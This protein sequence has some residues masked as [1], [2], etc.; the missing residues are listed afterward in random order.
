MSQRPLPPAVYWRRRLLIVAVVIAVGWI[1][2]K[3]VGGDDSTEDSEP[4][5][6][7]QVVP[8]VVPTDGTYDA[9]LPTDA[10]ACDPEAVRITPSVPVEQQAGG[11]VQ[12]DLVVSSA[13]PD[14]CTLE[15]DDAD[16]I[17]VISSGDAVVWDSTRCPTSLLD[18]P[19]ALAAGW[20]SLVSVQWSGRRSGG[21]CSSSEPAVG[22]GTYT[23][24]LGT[25]GGEPG[26]ATF[27]LTPG[28]A[29]PESESEGQG[30]G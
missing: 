19:V 27:S 14:P 6:A 25:L 23:V 22:A 7:P 15:P 20:S 11:A 16:L 28:G 17:A 29:A 5:A 26:D 1:G 2:M 30:D 13:G 10:S 9:S 21:G 4:S 8:A 12:I 3:L 18:D 24:K